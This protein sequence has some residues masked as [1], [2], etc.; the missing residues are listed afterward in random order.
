MEYDLNNP[1]TWVVYQEPPCEPLFDEELLRI[2]GKNP[3]GDPMLVKRWGATYR[4]KGV[5]VYKLC[6]T[7]PTLIGHQFRDPQSGEMRE[8]SL[9][10]LDQIP[11]G[12][13]S[14]PLY[15]GIELGELRWI[16][17]RWVSP[18]D[19]ETMGYFD[20]SLRY[21]P[22]E[23]D[24]GREAFHEFRAMVETGEDPEKA[25]M[26]VENQ[27]DRLR[28]LETDQELKTYF[29]PAWRTKGDYQFFF[30]L[31]R[32]NGMYHAP[33]G[34]ALEAIAA[35]WEYHQTTTPAQRL[36]D[37]EEEKARAAID[38]QQRIDALWSPEAPRERGVIAA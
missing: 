13:I 18:D 30:R 2:G 33:D 21:Q 19:L 32:K 14:V 9:G 36:A 4:N 23:T 6:D 25:L 1:A 10:Q 11:Q 38:R 8:V 3:N 29:D 5:L 7:E 16:I 28:N 31:E 35:M 34:E 27:V 26:R 12:T 15:R 22:T 17:E 24:F 20:E 37:E